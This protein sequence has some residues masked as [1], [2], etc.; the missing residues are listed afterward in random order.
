[1]RTVF[2]FFLGINILF[3][4]WQ[5]S[6]HN[7]SS[8]ASKVNLTAI[9]ANVAKLAL[10]NEAGQNQQHGAQAAPGSAVAGDSGTDS[11]KQTSALSVP[12]PPQQ[13]GPG[14]YQCFALGPF[15]EVG[16][17]NP[18]ALKLRDLGAITRESRHEKQIPSG[19]WVYLPRFENWKEARKKVMELEKKGMKDLFIMGRG[20]MQNAV[21]A[22]LFSSEGAAET[23][24]ARLK[25]LGAEAKVQ[26]QHTGTPEFWIDIDVEADKKQV[27]SAIEAIAKGLTVL[28]LV[29][30]KCD[31]N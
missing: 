1:M 18:I 21:S 7:P 6:T 8:P 27:V 17:A 12:L 9:P 16:Q 2:L 11:R 30:R 28:E 13:R 19:Y 31:D 29:P 10:I 3:F 14:D 20:S 5:S 4:I 22:G 25:R 15:K 23:R 24:R 26:I